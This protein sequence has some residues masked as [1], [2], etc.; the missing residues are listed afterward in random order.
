MKREEYINELRSRLHGLQEADIEDAI[1]YCEEYF[2][3]AESEEEAMKALGTPV[4]FAAQIKTESAF[5]TTKN[6]QNYRKPH[7]MMKSI[8]MILGGICALPIA[9]PLLLVAIILIVVFGL[10]LCIFVMVG[11]IVSVCAVYG[12]IATLLG[13]IFYANGVGDVLLYV[14][15]AFLFTG[16]AILAIL[17]TQVLIRKAM[18]VFVNQLSQ[19]YDHHRKGGSTYEA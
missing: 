11:M 17:G 8:L 1:R 18:P 2:D 16:L 10:L 15:V 19:F 5:K 9:L 3:E 6:P 14:G 4:K 7:S 13:S 12:A